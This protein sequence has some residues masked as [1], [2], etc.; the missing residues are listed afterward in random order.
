MLKKL[1]IYWIALQVILA[2][3]FIYLAFL[4]ILCILGEALLL[5][6]GEISKDTFYGFFIGNIISAVS[7]FLISHSFNKDVIEITNF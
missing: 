7:F 5:V 2:K 3:L 4:S 6:F 1:K